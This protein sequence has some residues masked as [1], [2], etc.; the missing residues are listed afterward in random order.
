M[1]EVFKIDKKENHKPTKG[2]VVDGSTRGNPGPS[3][4]KG[5][6][7]ETGKVLFYNKLSIATNNICE[8]IALV[9]GLVYVLEKKVDG[10][11][12]SDSKTAIAWVRN[13]R[14]KSS[15]DRNSENKDVC[16][17]LL[18]VI[19]LVKKNNFQQYNDYKYWQT[20]NWGENPA[21]FGNK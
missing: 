16:D 6:D 8:Y 19:D 2:I 3:E 13:K 1:L 15:F 9:H 17:L 5:I 14:V 20:S 21:D 10:P 12:Y 7:L 18:K 4:Y 11:V